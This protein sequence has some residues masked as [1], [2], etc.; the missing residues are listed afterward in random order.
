MK[1]IIYVGGAKGGVG[2]SLVSMLVLDLLR[3]QEPFLIETDQANPDV[4]K[5]YGG[6]VESITGDM[7][8]AT[9]WSEVLT[10]MHTRLDSGRPVVINSAA[11][12][13]AGVEQYGELFGA[14]GVDMLLLWAINAQKDGLILLDGF[15]KVVQPARSFVVKNGYFGSLDDFKLFDE[16]K[17]KKRVSGDAYV[18][19]LMSNI[20]NI[21][22]TQRKPLHEVAESLTFGD[23]LFFES[24]RK[25]AHAALQ[26][27]LE[28]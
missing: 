1:G 18:P 15:M 24:W 5:A 23:K 22:Y 10:E 25:K 3:E 2:K 8:S 20:A 4:L 14:L 13:T 28:G 16:S 17:I 9:G 12:N 19:A 26:P 11:R 6:C 27:I 21:V 7:D